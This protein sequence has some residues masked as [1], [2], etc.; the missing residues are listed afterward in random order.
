[1]GG[2]PA[3]KWRDGRDRD[4]HH[5]FSNGGCPFKFGANH[6]KGSYRFIS[7]WSLRTLQSKLIKVGAKLVRHACDVCFQ[8]ALVLIMLF[9]AKLRRTHQLMQLV[10][11]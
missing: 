10:P 9:A 7:H 1:M 8:M 11:V 2:A 3:R 4:L 5:P 6:L